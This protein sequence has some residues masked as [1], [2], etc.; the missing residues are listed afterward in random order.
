MDFPVID[1]TAGGFL[2]KMK[3]CVTCRI[4]RPPKSSHC[5]FCDLCVEGFDHHCPWVG[6]CIGKR[7]YRYFLCFITSVL[8]LALFNFAVC[9][10][11]FVDVAGESDGSSTE[12]F[13]HALQRATFSFIMLIYCTA[14]ISLLAFL[15][16]FHTELLKT[17]QTTAEKLKKTW[18]KRYLNIY[19]RSFCGNLAR[20]CRRQPRAS[21]ISHTTV[22]QSEGMIELRNELKKPDSH[23]IRFTQTNLHTP[24]E[25]PSPR[26]D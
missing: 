25:G 1:V 24:S 16:G 26:I 6:N 11:Q 3:Y 20:F 4:Y 17:G 13:E 23:D 22:V 8:S 12:A 2:Q 10:G 15:C 14:V 18:E 21:H 5:V 9:L 19:R 7:N